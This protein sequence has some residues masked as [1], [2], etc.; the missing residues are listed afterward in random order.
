MMGPVIGCENR[1]LKS[2]VIALKGANFRR[3]DRGRI[4]GTF[5]WP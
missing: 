3:L 4:A 2:A 1:G 5:D